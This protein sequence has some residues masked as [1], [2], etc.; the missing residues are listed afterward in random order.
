V[1]VE[2]IARQDRLFLGDVAEILSESGSREQLR[3][4]ALGYAPEVGALREWQRK[5]A[6]AIAA[7]GVCY[8]QY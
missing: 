6:L 1:R 3:T 7:A 2:S 4:I 8:R 5:I